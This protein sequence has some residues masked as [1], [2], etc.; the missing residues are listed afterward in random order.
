MVEDKWLL[1]FGIPVIVWLIWRAIMRTRE[2][3]KRIREYQ[4][5]MQANPRLPQEV[6]WELWD[7][8][9]LKKK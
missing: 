6:F 3:K 5:E 7:Q 2:I 8:R 9:D 4:D 1:I